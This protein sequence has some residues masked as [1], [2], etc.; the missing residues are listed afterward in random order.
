LQVNPFG[1]WA[2]SKL[3]THPELVK[4]LKEHL[5]FI[6]KYV[7]AHNIITFL[8]CPNVKSKYNL[9]D[10]IH[11]TMV[12]HWMH[13]LKFCWVKDHKGQYVDGP[14]RAEVVRYRQEVFLPAWY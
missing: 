1:I 13:A 9:K 2:K 4:E 6:D 8:S 7:Q 5:V 10:T 14:E 3:K 11:I 12:R